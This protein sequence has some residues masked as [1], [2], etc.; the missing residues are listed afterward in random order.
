ML[1]NLWEWAENIPLKK[2]LVFL[3]ICLISVTVFFSW[4]IVDSNNKDGI[5]TK[6]TYGEELL[7]TLETCVSKEHQTAQNLQQVY[8]DCTN[9]LKVLNKGLNKKYEIPTDKKV[10]LT[11]L[12]A[13]SNVIPSLLVVVILFFMRLSPIEIK[14]RRN[15]IKFNARY[16][17][18]LAAGIVVQ[19]YCLMKINGIDYNSTTNF[20]YKETMIFSTLLIAVVSTMVISFMDDV[21]NRLL[22][23]SIKAQHLPIGKK[24]NTLKDLAQ[25]HE[26]LIQQQ[27]EFSQL[28]QQNDKTPFTDKVKKFVLIELEILERLNSVYPNEFRGLKKHIK[29]WKNELQVLH[30]RKPQDLITSVGAKLNKDIRFIENKMKELK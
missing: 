6:Q 12:T 1:K 16:L 20:V 25:F 26:E 14:N 23:Y 17:L 4:Q 29:A 9:E 7:K 30:Q 10:E 15:L 28:F 11:L 27:I 21:V 18:I 2:L 3:T 13:V 22:K 5:L 8:T 19:L 24:N